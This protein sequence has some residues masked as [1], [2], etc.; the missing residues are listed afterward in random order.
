MQYMAIHVSRQGQAT[1]PK[2]TKLAHITARKFCVCIA[3]ELATRSLIRLAQI[4]DTLR[5]A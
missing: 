2:L 5:F 1:S 3:P 4:L